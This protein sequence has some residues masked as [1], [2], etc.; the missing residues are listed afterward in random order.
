MMLLPNIRLSRA[1]SEQDIAELDKMIKQV[2]SKAYA[3]GIEDAAK[4]CE[5][6]PMKKYKAPLM[7]VA[8]AIRKLVKP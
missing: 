7:I 1:L 2:Q 6:M 4:V 8:A 5:S 3:K